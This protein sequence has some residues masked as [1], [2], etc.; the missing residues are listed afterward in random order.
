MLRG[1]MASG[2][3]SV[4]CFRGDYLVAAESINQAADHMAMR[5]IL[6]GVRRPSPSQVADAEFS[7]KAFAA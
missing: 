5:R 2:R 1:D 3:F 6:K 7:L 4:F